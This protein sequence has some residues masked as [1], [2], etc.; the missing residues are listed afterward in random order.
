VGGLERLFEGADLVTVTPFEFGE[1]GGEG[2]YDAAR[3]FVL[4]RGRCCWWRCVLLLGPK[5]LHALSDSLDQRTLRLRRVQR[6]APVLTTGHQLLTHTV[7]VTQ[8]RQASTQ[9]ARLAGHA[10]SVLRPDIR[11]NTPP[12]VHHHK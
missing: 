8:T 5:L 11:P 4:G 9:V 10:H 3:G 2:A 7:G 1:L 6:L 12:C